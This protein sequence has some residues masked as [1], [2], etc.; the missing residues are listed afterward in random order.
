MTIT[1]KDDALVAEL[2][3]AKPGNL[4]DMLRLVGFGSMVRGFRT[5]LRG[6]AMDGVAATNKYVLAAAFSVTLPD[7]AK[8]SDIVKAYARAGTGTKGPL[9]IDGGGDG[10]SGSEPAAGHVAVAPNGDL[11]FNH[12]DAWTSVDVVY[13][14]EKY[15]IVELPLPVAS[16]ALTL[17]TTLGAGLFLLE[18]ESLAGTVVSKMIVDKPGTSVAAGHAAMSLDKLTVNFQATDAVT[19]ARVKFGVYSKINVDSLLET[20]QNYV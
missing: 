7:D 3:R 11:L 9:T 10:F 20:S 2:N 16:N 5:H 4:A 15:D 13:V 19:S 14:P 17:P 6:K 12:T 1:V 8:A 18:V